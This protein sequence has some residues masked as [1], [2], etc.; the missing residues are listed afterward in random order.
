M[1]KVAAG[2]M[3]PAGGHLLE[4]DG[5]QR[6]VRI[7]LHV[8]E[9]VGDEE[10]RD[11]D[12]ERGSHVDHRAPPR[13]HPRLP[14]DRQAVAHGLDARVGAGAHAVALKEEGHEPEPPHRGADGVDLVACRGRDPRESRGVGDHRVGDDEDVRQDEDAEDR[15]P[16]EDR[17]LHA[18][19]VDE[20][21]P[22]D[23]GDAERELVGLRRVREEAEEGVGAAGDRDRDREDVVDQERAAGDDAGRGGEEL[24]RDQVAAA[25]GREERDDLRVAGADGDD[26]DDRGQGHE[27]AQV[28]VAEERLEGLLRAVARR[29]EPVGAEAHPGEHGYEGEAVEQVPV[30]QRLLASE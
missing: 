23:P 6:L 4:E 8:V 9:L 19:Q 22:H 13:L 11:R 16:D 24:A 2:G 10:A 15:H 3:V 25:P 30:R 28:R 7:D 14:Q 12:R 26:R 17:L 27:E 21:E 29:R 20:R 1:T 5:V 18:A